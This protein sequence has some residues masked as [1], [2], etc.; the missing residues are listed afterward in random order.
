MVN[1]HVHVNEN[2]KITIFILAYKKQNKATVCC[3]L[4]CNVEN[5]RE[6]IRFVPVAQ[7]PH[8]LP[9]HHTK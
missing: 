7:Q 5:N 8:K 9:Y 3:F 4:F 6:I 1:I 2:V